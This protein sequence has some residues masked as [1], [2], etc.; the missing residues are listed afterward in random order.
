VI[1]QILV[2]VLRGGVG[3]GVVAFLEFY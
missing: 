3:N 1:G 2:G